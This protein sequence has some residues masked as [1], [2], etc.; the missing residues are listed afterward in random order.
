MCRMVYFGAMSLRVSPSISVVIP[1]LDEAG[2]IGRTLDM[3]ANQTHAPAQIVVCDG[4][5]SDETRA[6]VQDRV[7]SN[8]TVL[9]LECERGTARQRNAGARAATSELI[10][11]LDADNSP[12]PSFCEDVA[13]S[14]QRIPFAVACPWFVARDSVAIYFCY[15]WFNILFFLGQGWLRTG[16]GV[17]LISPRAIWEKTGGFRE[18]LHLGEDVEFLRRCARFGLHRHLFVP[19]ETSGR[20]F[21]RDGIIRLMWFYAVISPLVLLGRWERLKQIEYKPY[22]KK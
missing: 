13:R 18:D 4:G 7:R 22:T 16:S 5:S 1:T 3:L 2:N 19:L 11:F 21:A 12:S 6:I 20:R 8:S 9:C 15:F 10:V 14:Y 17:C